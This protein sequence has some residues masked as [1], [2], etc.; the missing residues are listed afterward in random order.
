MTLFT[1]KIS[2][3]YPTETKHGYEAGSLYPKGRCH[4][5]RDDAQ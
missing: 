3:L 2:A 1:V 5:R 4:L